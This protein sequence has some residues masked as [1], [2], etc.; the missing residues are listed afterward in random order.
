[1]PP[2]HDATHPV[3]QWN[4]GRIVCQGSVIQHWLNDVKVIDFDYTDSQFK[5]EV[6]LLKDRGGNLE[7]RG[8]NLSLQDHGNP[9]WYRNFRLRSIAANE[10]IGHATV[11][12]EKLSKEVLAVEATKIEGIM[13]RRA[14]QKAKTGEQ[15]ATKKA[16]QSNRK[17]TSD[18]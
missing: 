11:A 7:A 2:G 13:G 17:A 6:D 18:K 4:S 12:P 5:F 1:M 10:D 14:K 8:A 3:G 9:V 16:E 15:K